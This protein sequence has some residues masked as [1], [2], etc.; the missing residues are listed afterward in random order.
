M[1]EIPNVRQNAWRLQ[2][3]VTQENYFYAMSQ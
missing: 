3:I 2:D 1:H